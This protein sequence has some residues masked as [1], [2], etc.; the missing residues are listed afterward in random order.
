MPMMRKKARAKREEARPVV[1]AKPEPPPEP[2]EDVLSVL[3]EIRDKMPSK[4][5]QLFASVLS[6]VIAKRGPADSEGKT[7]EGLVKL[8][9]DFAEMASSK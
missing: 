1:E 8:A 5:D 7:S 3:K 9:R 6:G 2:P 4:E